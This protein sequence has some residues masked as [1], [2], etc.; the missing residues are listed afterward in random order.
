MK[1]LLTVALVVF[2]FLSV[3][4]GCG[5]PAQENP[6][7]T[8][9]ASTQAA[10]STAAEPAKL[11]EITIPTYR[12]GDNVGAKFFLPQVERFNKKYEG[13]YKVN[14]EEVQ[15][16]A[17][18]DKIKQLYQQNMLPPLILGGDKD[19]INQVIVANKKYYDLKSWL[20]SKP[21][22]KARLLP[23]SLAYNTQADGSIVGLPLL[24]TRP[25]GVFYNQTM[26]KPSKRIGE[27]NWDE[28]DQALGSNKIAFM[29]SE[30]AWTTQLFL[31]ALIVKNG[32][33]D[34]L[35][36]GAS[37]ERIKDFSDPIWEK[38]FGELQKYLQKYKS[39]NTLG[40]AYADAANCF[41]SKQAAMI[42]NGSWMIGDFKAPDKWSNGFKGDDVK[43]DIFP[44]NVAFDNLYGYWWWMP[45]GLPQDQA[46]AALAFLE[47]VASPE[48]IEGFMLA[49]GGIAPMQ[50][51]SDSYKT[52][53]A[54]DRL[55]SEYSTA[56]NDKTTIT[57]SFSDAVVTAVG[58][59]QGAFP[60]TLPKLIDGSMTPAQ[61]AAEMTKKAQ[62]AAKQ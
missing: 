14:L 15:Q 40:A 10:A 36:N 58:D 16:D 6:Q 30:N 4:A 59:T 53:L 26:M 50:T 11:V 47:F 1:R 33:A 60:T 9:Q 22:L 25:I 20:D 43:A 35:K 3:V 24:V 52:E 54:K 37:K 49:E 12:I 2:M 46:D 39:A 31:S 51:M 18:N 29:T 28:L 62:E 17:Y 44:G 23:D 48:E 42:Q 41:M 45:A 56:V 61:F 21:D 8:A 27:M 38:S 13:K 34:L 19:W 32:G 5:T 55:L 7:T 57:P